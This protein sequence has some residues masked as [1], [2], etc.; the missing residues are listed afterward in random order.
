ME[1]MFNER[2]SVGGERPPQHEEFDENSGFGK[3]FS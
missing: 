2:L 1:R 3:W